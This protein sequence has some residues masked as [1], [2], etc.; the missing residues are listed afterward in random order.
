VDSKETN[1]DLKVKANADGF[2]ERWLPVTWIT[3]KVNN[4]LNGTSAIHQPLLG[5]LRMLHLASGRLLSNLVSQPL[6]P[7][8]V[9]T[10]FGPLPK[11][12]SQKILLVR[13]V[14][15]EPSAAKLLTTNNVVLMEMTQLP[16]LLTQT[17]NCT[18]Q[19]L[20]TLSIS[21]VNHILT[22]LLPP[23]LQTTTALVFSAMIT[24][25]L[26]VDAS[27]RRVLMEP[28]YQFPLR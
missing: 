25:W 16:V 9:L 7:Q 28:G 12:S 17:A 22:I 10:V 3:L 19:N 27:G 11:N 1:A 6:H 18:L 15:L 4:S 26:P 21:T 5:G 14:L 20:S 8:W 13:S 24:A 23:L 2:K